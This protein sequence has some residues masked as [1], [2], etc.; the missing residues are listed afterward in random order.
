MNSCEPCSSGA[1][2]KGLKD[3]FLFMEWEIRVRFPVEHLKYKPG[4]AISQF[5]F[6]TGFV[7]MFTVSIHF[8]R[9]CVCVQYWGKNGKAFTECDEIPFHRVVAHYRGRPTALYIKLR[10]V[11][12]GSMVKWGNLPWETQPRQ[13]HCVSH[14]AQV[15]RSCWKAYTEAYTPNLGLK[16]PKLGCCLS[17]EG[18]SVSQIPPGYAASH[19]CGIL[20]GGGS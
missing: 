13:P 10:C 2:F 14:V 18:R 3:W 11:T 8:K 16:P 19:F 5:W 20:K 9:L 17:F 4:C 15:L 7:W 12:L 6:L 1:S